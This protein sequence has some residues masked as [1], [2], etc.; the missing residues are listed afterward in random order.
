M[1][2]DDSGGGVAVTRSNK[3]VTRFEPIQHLK[4]KSAVIYRVSGD[5]RRSITRNEW[6]ALKVAFDRD[7]WQLATRRLFERLVC[8]ISVV[9]ETAIEETIRRRIAVGVS[10][11]TGRARADKDRKPVG[12]VGLHRVVLL[13]ACVRLTGLGRWEL[14]RFC[15]RRPA[16][17]L[18]RRCHTTV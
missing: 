5:G 6:P 2:A 11:R 9:S 16:R 7:R 13:Y 4:L 1:W 12:C 18:T 3:A 17:S 15:G 8:F 14:I 10:Q